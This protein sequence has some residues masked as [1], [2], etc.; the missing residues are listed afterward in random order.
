M[1]A[2]LGAQV[3]GAGREGV[4]EGEV[5][6]KEEKLYTKEKRVKAIYQ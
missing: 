6:V 5:H 4:M 2:W 3:A 1:A